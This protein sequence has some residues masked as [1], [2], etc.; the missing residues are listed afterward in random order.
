MGNIAHAESLANSPSPWEL[1]AESIAV[2]IRWFGLLVG[3][4]LVNVTGHSIE[5]R[6]VLHAILTAG[7]VYALLD[8]YFSLRGKVFLGRSP[9][10]IAAMEALF[11]GLLCFFDTGLESP[12]RYYYFL[13]LICSAIRHPPHV[14]YASCA[15]HC[16]SYGA[17]YLALPP[18][19]QQP[20]TFALTIVM[21]GWVTWAS[22][23]MALLLKRV[24]DYLGQ[25]N[26]ALRQHQAELEE[27]IAE[28]T[29]ELQ[30]SQAHVLH[31]EKMAAFGLLAAGIAHEVGN[32]LT[33]ISS[34]VQMLQ[35]READPYTLNKL[36]LV[37]GQL[38]R[39]RTT[40]RELIEF[41]RPASAERTRTSLGDILEEALNIAKYYKRTRGKIATPE[42]PPDLPP[43]HGVRDQLVQ[44]F[45]NLI[46]NAIDATDRDGRIELSVTRGPD[47]VEVA[48]RDNG[49]GIA[50]EHAGRLF[51]PYFTTKAHGTGLGL[52]VTRQLVNEHGGTVACEPAPGGGTVF[53]VRLPLPP[54]PSAPPVSA[55]NRE[56]AAW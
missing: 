49:H 44:V 24:G 3:Y 11:I 29:R 17:L 9:F 35:R 36:G 52:F 54:S 18:D 12:F 14:T 55:Q 38:Q 27:R 16:L 20:A 43:L 51:Q 21:L 34:M 31:Q 33:S 15:A 37:S 41:S 39:I 30:E 5:R 4:V 19:A 40:L 7:T 42:L 46:L 13:S 10:A 28:R 48:V 53:R 8:T 22:N 6:A 25:L 50:P 32:P 45:L 2:R 26:E 47:T 1:D 23:A 56:E